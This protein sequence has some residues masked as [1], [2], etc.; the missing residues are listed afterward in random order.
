MI[1]LKIAASTAMACAIF[2][3][4]AIFKKSTR[5]KKQN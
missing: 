3:S 4:E 1:E 5:I 2:D